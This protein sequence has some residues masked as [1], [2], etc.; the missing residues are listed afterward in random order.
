MPQRASF[1]RLIDGFLIF[2]PT[3]LRRLAQGCRV[4]ATTLGKS[5]HHISTPT[6]LRPSRDPDGT[7]LGFNFPLF[8]A[9]QGSC[10]YAATLG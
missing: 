10:E 4:L 6:G 9:P 2:A 3:G 8:L 7:P 5:I 1:C